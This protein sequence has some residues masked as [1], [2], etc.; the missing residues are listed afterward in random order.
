[1][2]GFKHQ[3]LE[4]VASSVLFNITNPTLPPDVESLFFAFDK[5]MVVFTLISFWLF[6]YICLSSVKMPILSRV[7]EFFPIQGIIMFCGFITKV[8]MGFMDLDFSPTRDV[9]KHLMITPI[10][11]HNAYSLYHPNCYGQL[12]TILAISLT[13]TV[14]NVG[15]LA[16]LLYVVYA[17]WL[18][19][20]L[21]VFDCLT[22]SSIISAVGK[23]KVCTITITQHFLLQILWKFWQ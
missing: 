13:A 16:L 7:G 2:E 22:F 14:L 17:P 10:I 4:V 19:P 6:L 21:T 3:M 5:N 11:L 9:L 20:D 12:R 18:D 15:I 1:M 23:S 8:L